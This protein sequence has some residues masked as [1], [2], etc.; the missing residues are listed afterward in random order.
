MT[1]EF[2]KLDELRVL[3]HG[4]KSKADRR[5]AAQLIRNGYA[6]GAVREDM[7][8]CDDAV[9]DVT[10]QGSTRIGQKRAAYLQRE[11]ARSPAVRI[12]VRTITFLWPI[13]IVVIGGLILHLLIK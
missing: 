1:E 6:R 4:P 12:F 7:Q 8:S 2:S 11:I 5:I 3:K 10:W 9:L 13:A